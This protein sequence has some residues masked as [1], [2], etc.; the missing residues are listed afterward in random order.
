M[1]RPSAAPRWKIT[2]RR[3]RFAAP[4]LSAKTA[5]VRKD[6]IA[7][8]PTIARAPDLRNA[9]RVKHIRTPLSAIRYPPYGKAPLALGFWLLAKASE[10]LNSRSLETSN[11][12]TSKPRNLGTSEPL[13]IIAA[14]TP[15][16]RV[17]VL[18]P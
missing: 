10:A 15:G 8:V 9:R 5:R 2:T 12:E 1:L 17:A 14:G 13:L 11:L 7:A 16:N 18:R 4:E 3:L 6:G